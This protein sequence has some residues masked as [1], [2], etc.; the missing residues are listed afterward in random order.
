MITKEFKV[1]AKSKNTNSFGLY[2]M[3]LVAKDGEAFK[4]HASQYNVK[5]KDEIVNATVLINEETGKVT[6]TYFTGHELTQRIEKAPQEV[7][8]E[9]WK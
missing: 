7:I 6:A 9:V 3:I 4:S 1:V 5:D 2:Q 8:E